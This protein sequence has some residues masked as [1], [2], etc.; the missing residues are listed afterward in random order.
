[1]K[2][3]TILFA[4]I[5]AAPIGNLAAEEKQMTAHGTFEVNV[6]QQQTGEKRFGRYFLDKQFHGN[7]E[8][9]SKG[10]MLAAETPVQ[11]SG[12]YVAFEL[13]S[14]VLEGRRGTFILQHQGTMRNGKYA[15]N[16][17]VV[18]DSGTDQ[19]TGISG[20]M[21]I[22]IEGNK[23]FYEFNYMLEEHKGLNRQ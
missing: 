22:T 8:A 23:H 18:P 5:L 10:E 17:T 7:L 6:T 4:L 13:V 14:G 11:G 15:M 9:T 21:S 12:A 3:T 20:T 16:V 19:L 2:S 1:M